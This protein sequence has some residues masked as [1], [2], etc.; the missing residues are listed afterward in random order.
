MT[1]RKRI[2]QINNIGFVS[3][4]IAGTDGVSLETGKWAEVLEELRYSCF[5]FAG[6][7]DR[8]EE[9]CMLGAKAYFNHPEISSISDAVFGNITRSEDVTERIRT[10][11]RELTY[12]VRSVNSQALGGR[13]W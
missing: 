9:R 13:F 10:V 1:K 4:G 12:D 8:P 11:K 2:T 3:T 6:E 5:Y 7:L